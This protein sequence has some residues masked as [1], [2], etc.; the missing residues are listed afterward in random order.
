VITAAAPFTQPA[1]LASKTF[2]AIIDIDID[3]VVGVA[4]ISLSSGVGRSA[5]R[6]VGVPSPGV[7]VITRR[8]ASSSSPLRRHALAVRGIRASRSPDQAERG[9]KTGGLAL[10]HRIPRGHLWVLAVTYRESRW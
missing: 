7:P 5:A 3:I 10:V 6:S 4:V 2:T 8:D 1:S 9:T